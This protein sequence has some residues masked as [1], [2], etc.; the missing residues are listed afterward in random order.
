[1]GAAPPSF[2]VRANMPKLH[3]AFERFLVSQLRERFGFLG[4][5]IRLRL[6]RGK[7]LARARQR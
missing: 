2:L 4:T 3:F 1:V 6:V 5:P 7:R